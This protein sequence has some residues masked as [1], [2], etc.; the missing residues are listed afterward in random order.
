MA[1]STKTILTPLPSGGVGGRCLGVGSVGSVGS[2]AFMPLL[3]IRACVDSDSEVSGGTLVGHGGAGLAWQT[4][5]RL[6]TVVSSHVTVVSSQVTVVS[7]H[8]TELSGPLTVASRRVCARV[9][10]KRKEKRRV[11][12]VLRVPDKMLPCYT[13]QSRSWARR[14]RRTHG[15]RRFSF[16]ILTRA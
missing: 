12:C 10:S 16:T 3:R 13:M 1:E 11:L 2:M 8:V 7:S 5:T 4:V 6:L 9:Y 15:T 14:T